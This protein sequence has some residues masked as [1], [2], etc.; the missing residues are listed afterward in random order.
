VLTQEKSLH[1]YCAK[2]GARRITLGQS[3]RVTKPLTIPVTVEFVPGLYML[4]QGGAATIQLDGELVAGRQP[5]FVGF[6]PGEVRGLFGGEPKLPEW[7][8]SAND[9]IRINC[10][11]QSGS[12]AHN[13]GNVVSLRLGQYFVSRPLDLGGT[14]TDLIGAGMWKTHIITTENWT[15]SGLH[16]HEWPANP[17][18]AGNH[19]AV[20]WIGSAVPMTNNSFFTGVRGV[21]IHCYEA[22]LANAPHRR[23]TGI[24]SAG[25]CE[26]GTEIHDV[27]V[28]NATGAGIGF[29]AHESGVAVLNGLRVTKTWIV[30]AMM[31]DSYGMLFPQHSNNVVVDGATVDMTLPKMNSAE[32]ATGSPVYPA[33]RFVSTWPRTAIRA[34]GNMSVSNVHIEG[35]LW[36]VEVAQNYGINAISVDRI[37][38]R[39]LMDANQVWAHDGRRST[40]EQPASTP[41]SACGAVVAFTSIDWD[42][43]RN[44]KDRFFG[45]NLVSNGTCG[46]VLR[47]IVNNVNV[48]AY[49]QGQYPDQATGGVSEYVRGPA[50]APGNFQLLK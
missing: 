39:G 12:R 50:W 16:T 30:G 17:S 24:S 2:P 9:D 18:G 5:V 13:I 14:S 4:V 23:V 31:R 11:I 27:S 22:A 37:N 35:A 7:W 8:Q 20:I 3:I 15:A 47:D 25:W 33:P 42:V 34:M 49:G 26:E 41:L 21:S 38:A 44:Y 19:A 28:S 36:G 6:A 46:F 29:P 32:Y 40:T 1:E 10:A 43:T 45:T 48:S